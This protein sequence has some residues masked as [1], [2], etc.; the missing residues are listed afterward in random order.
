MA[1]KSTLSLHLSGLDKLS[2]GKIKFFPSNVGFKSFSPYG[3]AH[4]ILE[5]EKTVAE[6]KSNFF[7]FNLT[8][9]LIRAAKRRRLE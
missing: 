6:I 5:N 3:A 2:C 4:A 9:E 7:I 1:P 8:P